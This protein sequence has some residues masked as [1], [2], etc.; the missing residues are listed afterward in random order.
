MEG[1]KKQGVWRFFRL[2]MPTS[3]TATCNICKANVSRG[4]GSTAKSNT[5]NIIKHLV[6]DQLMPEAQVLVSGLK[7]VPKQAL[8]FLV[9]LQ[10][11]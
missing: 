8:I 6:S 3:F 9:K 2:S 11:F 10:Q 7:I 4:G 1:A 5:T